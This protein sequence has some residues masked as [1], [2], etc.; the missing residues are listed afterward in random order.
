MIYFAA[1]PI[2]FLYFI[3]FFSIAKKINLIDK[4]NFRKKHFGDIPIIGGLIIFS[5]F[6]TLELFFKFIPNDLIYVF[7]GSIPVLI[8]SFLDDIRHRHWSLRIIVQ[9]ASSIFIILFSGIQVNMLGSFLFLDSITIN[10]SSS[11]FTI[12]C[13]VGLT[14]AINMFDGID[15]LCSS[16]LILG[17]GA[18]LLFAVSPGINTSMIIVMML[19]IFFFC[20]PNLSSSKYKIFLGD[21][22]SMPLG[23]IFGWLLVYF[24]QLPENGVKPELIVW[25]AA[26][27][28][29]DSLRVMFVRSKENR[30]VFSADRTHLHH[31]LLD[32]NFSQKLT[33]VI[34]FSLNA[35]LI[36][37]ALLISIFDKLSLS[38]LFFMLWIVFY[39]YLIKRI[40]E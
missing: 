10:S 27:P 9:I 13:I 36:L 25:I 3:L 11:L 7:I 30:S 40:K 39:F 32:L 4:P 8:I 24:S 26:I 38:Y 17:L 14:N 16:Y 31:L 2:F 23:F 20:I 29:I 15:G 6:Y 18:L 35:I 21:A 12:F 34:I 33:L 22:G 1:L 37:I 5:S 19:L 28:I